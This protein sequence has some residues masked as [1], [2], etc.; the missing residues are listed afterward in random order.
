M[1]KLKLTYFDIHG[2]R[3]EP[4]RIALSIGNIPFEDDRV[5]F[6]DFSKRRAEMPFHALPVLEIDGVKVAQSNSINR[7]VGKLADLYPNDPLQA[8]FCDE[9][10]DAIEDVGVR[11]SPTFQIKDEEEKKAAR[12]A[13]AEGP[14]TV[15]LKQLEQR[16]ERGGD[17]FV[18]GRLSM[19]DLKV[20]VW[21]KHLK[22]GRLD[23]V[24][25][26]LPDRAAPKLVA[27]FERVRNHPGVR[28]Y[29]AKLGVEP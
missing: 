23:H 26:D 20:Y 4:A 29:Y 2:A 1:A 18:G 28:A 19:A 14:F 16:L 11:T 7:Y 5:S 22:S 10:M 17:W 6:A 27:H 8:L 25:T 3:G 9:I 15:Y 13:L 21:L 12:K 24:P